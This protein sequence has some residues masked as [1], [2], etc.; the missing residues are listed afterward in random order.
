M[1]GGRNN[2]NPAPATR[3]KFLKTGVLWE[4]RGC[5]SGIVGAGIEDYKVPISPPYGLVEET[6]QFVLKARLTNYIM[7]GFILRLVGN[8]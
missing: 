7:I 2:S 6:A 5:F 1:H 8:A 4:F 3:R